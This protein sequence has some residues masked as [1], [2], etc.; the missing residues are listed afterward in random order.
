M[1]VRQNKPCLMIYE[2]QS[3]FTSYFIVQW[4]SGGGGSGKG[5]QMI[6]MKLNLIRA[7]E[8]VCV[9]VCVYSCRHRFLSNAVFPTLTGVSFQDKKE[10]MMQNKI[11]HCFFPFCLEQVSGDIWPLNS[12]LRHLGFHCTMGTFVL[13]IFC[14]KSDTFT[15]STGY[16]NFST[17]PLFSFPCLVLSWSKYIITHDDPLRLI[18]KTTSVND[19]KLARLHP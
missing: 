19:G 14:F 11:E 10:Q 6:T 4:D 15:G 17:I 12:P 2:N 3:H 18:Q 1:F 9:C 5:W 13:D 8:T 7:L 16:T